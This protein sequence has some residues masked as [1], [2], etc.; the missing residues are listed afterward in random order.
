MAFLSSLPTA[1]NKKR[2]GDPIAGVAT[3]QAGGGGGG[4]AGGGG[5]GGGGR[6]LEQRSIKQLQSQMRTVLSLAMETYLFPKDNTLGEN[7][8]KFMSA[9][10]D[11][12]PERPKK[13]EKGTGHPW[14]P[15]RYGLYMTLVEF[16]L[17]AYK[18]NSTMM[19][20]MKLSF[21][22]LET[23]IE[24]LGGV[25][26]V[27]TA[28]I[29]AGDCANG[30][31][32]WQVFVNHFESRETK[33]GR[34]V[35]HATPGRGFIMTDVAKANKI[36]TMDVEAIWTVLT[37]PLREFR[38]GGTAPMNPNERGMQQLLN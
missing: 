29:I 9:Y 13:G 24:G 27:A 36:S 38:E 32:T 34:Q 30:F 37:Y 33:D 3:P 31:K 18:T 19:G 35:L 5:G 15:A 22:Y 10:N 8:R 16:A 20:E 26:T 6:K 25:V 11:Q 23:L 12:K 17:T 21:P 7:L 4:S 28:M 2:K 1:T 14:G